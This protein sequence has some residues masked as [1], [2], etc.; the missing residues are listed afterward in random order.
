[1]LKR[2][3]A[4]W[5]ALRAQSPPPCSLPHARLLE[6]GPDDKLVIECEHAISIE[7]M[8]RL[9]DLMSQWLKAE[10]T[11]AL[12]LDHGMRLLAVRRHALQPDA[13]GEAR[14]ESPA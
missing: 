12:V 9:N 6:L 11:S 13:S 7:A 5:S 8:R 3:S 2:L 10:N 4:A 1:M 14:P